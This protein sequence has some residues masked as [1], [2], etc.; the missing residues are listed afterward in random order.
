MTIVG[1][2]G[3]GRHHRG[4]TMIIPARTHTELKVDDIVL[5]E[6]T[7]GELDR[8]PQTERLEQLTIESDNERIAVQEPSMADV[9]FNF[10]IDS[11]WS[12][13]KRNGLS[14][15]IWSNF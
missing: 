7:A 6:D 10:E 3:I 1:P 11:Y 4:R 12:Y 13:R 14:P 5:A 15:T 9:L 8:F 2:K